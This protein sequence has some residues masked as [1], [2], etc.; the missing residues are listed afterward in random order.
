M[1]YMLFFPKVKIHWAKVFIASFIVLIVDIVV[2]QVE[3]FLTMK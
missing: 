2:R 3:A 1:K